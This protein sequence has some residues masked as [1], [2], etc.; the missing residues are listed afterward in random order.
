MRVE[1]LFSFAW[2]CWTN[3][4]RHLKLQSVCLWG[5]LREFL[6]ERLKLSSCLMQWEPEIY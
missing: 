3:V 6:S 2:N 5:A 1:R 4:A